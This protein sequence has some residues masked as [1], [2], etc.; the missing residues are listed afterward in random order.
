MGAAP[1]CTGARRAAAFATAV[2]AAVVVAVPASAATFG[3]EASSAAVTQELW[4][5]EVSA[6]Y[7]RKATPAALAQ[8]KRGG[9]NALVLD[10]RTLTATQASSIS[11]NAL[12][13]GLLV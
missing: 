4:P 8:L 10:R 7:A 1:T 11:R 12:R 9:V 6:G 13:L 2:V 3:A 5:V